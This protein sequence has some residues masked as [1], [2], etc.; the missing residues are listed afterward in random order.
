VNEA[1]RSADH[2]TD[3]RDCDCDFVSST[4]ASKFAGC[5]TPINDHFVTTGALIHMAPHL[6][7]STGNL[8][9]KAIRPK[10]TGAMVE[11]GLLPRAR[12]KSRKEGS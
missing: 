8:G 10:S 3:K 2:T 11:T 5:F 1:K 6:L 4:L 9:K 7:A 12:S